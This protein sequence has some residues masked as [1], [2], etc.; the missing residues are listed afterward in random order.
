MAEAFDYVVVGLGGLG[1]AT[2]H[3]RCG[4]PATRALPTHSISSGA[5]TAT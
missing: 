3:Q 1:S 4:T 2:A 5:Y